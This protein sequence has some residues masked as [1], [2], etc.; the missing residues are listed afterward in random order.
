MASAVLDRDIFAIH[1]DIASRKAA[2]LPGIAGAILSL[3][4]IV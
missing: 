2:I 3:S 4:L 1:G